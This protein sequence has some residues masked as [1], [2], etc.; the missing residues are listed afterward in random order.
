MHAGHELLHGVWL[1]DLEFSTRLFD[2]CIRQLRCSLQARRSARWCVTFG[3]PAGSSFGENVRPFVL[4]IG[5]MGDTTLSYEPEFNRVA[6]TR[7][8]ALE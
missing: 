6:A 2:N 7:T 4:E 5:H 1:R 3:S 8:A